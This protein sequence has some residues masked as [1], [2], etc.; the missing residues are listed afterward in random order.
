MAAQDVQQVL[1]E[2]AALHGGNSETSAAYQHMGSSL[3]EIWSK[4]LQEEEEEDRSDL[5]FDQGDI[6]KEWKSLKVAAERK[7]ENNMIGV[8]NVEDVRPDSEF[9]IAHSKVPPYLAPSA[10]EEDCGAPWIDGDGNDTS[11]LIDGCQEWEI[12]QII[13]AK[14]MRHPY[15]G[16]TKTVCYKATFKGIWPRWNPEPPWQCLDDFVHC[17]AMIRQYHLDHPRKPGYHR[18][19]WYPE[20]LDEFRSEQSRIEGKTQSE[21]PATD[22]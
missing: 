4:I 17:S 3:D 5:A 9:V 11:I 14:L 18:K 13:D 6:F 22:Q 7:D 20:D 12:E 19:D 2:C 8:N 21:L 16:N 10:D 15:L 1:S